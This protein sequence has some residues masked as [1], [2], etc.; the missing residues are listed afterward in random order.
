MEERNTKETPTNREQHP[1]Q[2]GLRDGMKADEKSEA[3]N[4]VMNECR[5]RENEWEEWAALEKEIDEPGSGG[6]GKGE[7]KMQRQ[8]DDRKEWMMGSGNEMEGDRQREVKMWE[9]KEVRRWR[10]NQFILRA[11]E[12]FSG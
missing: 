2:E 12:T 4:E 7:K 3:E 6:E 9:R 11:R 8:G 10:I 5:E 1:D